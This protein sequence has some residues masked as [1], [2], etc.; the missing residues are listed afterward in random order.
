MW[1]DVPEAARSLQLNP[2]T[3]R[4]QIKLGKLAARRLGGRFYIHIDEVERYRRESLRKA[5]A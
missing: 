1:Y 2:A 3:V 4:L 5:S